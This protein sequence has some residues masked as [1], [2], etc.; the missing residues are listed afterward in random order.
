[1][2]N[3]KGN[4]AVITIIVVIVAITAG[5]VGWLLAKNSQAPAP[6]SIAVQ[7]PATTTPVTQQTQPAVQQT[8]P[9]SQSTTTQ[10]AGNG[11]ET[12]NKVYFE[13]KELGIKFLVDSS[14]KNDLIYKFNSE[15]NVAYLS[16]KSLV[17]MDAGCTAENAP[18][19]AISKTKGTPEIDD[20]VFYAARKDSIKQFN[21]FF[22]YFSGPQAPCA[23][24]QEDI[25][26]VN[27]YNNQL[28]TKVYFN[29]LSCVATN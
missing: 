24:K 26:R 1:M 10:P 3:K 18:L 28:R 12:G 14:I 15:N 9:T 21:G 25:E 13:I 7:Q 20:K 5:V 23:L 11:C 4:V 27:V 8:A 22:V 19:A 6:Q 2:K 29:D 16:A 17:A